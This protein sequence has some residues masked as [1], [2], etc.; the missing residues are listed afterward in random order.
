MNLYNYW[1]RL[2]SMYPTATADCLAHFQQQHRQEWRTKFKDPNKILEYLE[3]R[4]I[5]I[6]THKR[7]KIRLVLRAYE[8]TTTTAFHYANREAALYDAIERAFRLLE[9]RALRRGLENQRMA[10]LENHGV[11]RRK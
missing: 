11:R 10:T 5:H 9:Q 6:V 3:R 4:Q 2:K 8:E 1:L 7:D